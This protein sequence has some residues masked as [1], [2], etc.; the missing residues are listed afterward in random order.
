MILVS[1]ISQTPLALRASIGILKGFSKFITE[2][3][4]FF[5]VHGRNCDIRLPSTFGVLKI[6]SATAW[7]IRATV[8]EIL[9]C[10]PGSLVLFAPCCKSFSRMYATQCV[11]GWPWV[12][13]HGVGSFKISRLVFHACTPVEFE[14]NYFVGQPCRCRYTSG[15]TCFNPYG[16]CGYRFVRTGNILACWVVLMILLCSSLGL[17]WMMEQPSG[18]CLT[19]LP[20]IQQLWSLVDAALFYGFFMFLLFSRLG[21]EDMSGDH[22]I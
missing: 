12:M 16:N 6:W 10:K 19:I 4:D 15:R 22:Y 17:R 7:Y 11:G 9:R 18:T 14:H 3:V 8:N 1:L 13:L 20:R 2:K 5:F 21:L